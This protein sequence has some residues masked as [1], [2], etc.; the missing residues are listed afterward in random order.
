LPDLPAHGLVGCELPLQPARKMYRLLESS[1]KP[2]SIFGRAALRN[3]GQASTART[4]RARLEPEIPTTISSPCFGGFPSQTQ[5]QRVH[6]APS[7]GRRKLQAD[8]PAPKG[9]HGRT[10][11]RGGSRQAP[12]PRTARRLARKT[13]GIIR[14]ATKAVKFWAQRRFHPRNT[15][16]AET[17]PKREFI[18]VQLRLAQPPFLSKKP[19]VVNRRER[20]TGKSARA[21]KPSSCLPFLAEPRNLRS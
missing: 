16:A 15:M 18:P 9:L 3:P 10:K 1:G 8:P 21:T 13:F 4:R 19:V 5:G 20:R 12:P 6:P 7:R 14:P 17:G 11:L 2:A